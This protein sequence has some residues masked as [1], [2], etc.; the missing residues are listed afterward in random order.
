MLVT[1]SNLNM[2]ERH[3]STSD[4]SR[5]GN[6]ASRQ[7]RQSPVNQNHWQASDTHVKRRLHQDQSNRYNC[8]KVIDAMGVLRQACN[9]VEPEH[10]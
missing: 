10:A 7:M 6:A 1:P 2:L 4:N 3:Q 9:A 8:N 5:A